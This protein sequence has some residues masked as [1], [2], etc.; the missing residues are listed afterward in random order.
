[1]AYVDSNLND[2][3][4]F[5]NTVIISKAPRFNNVFDYDNNLMLYAKNEIIK[6]IELGYG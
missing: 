6:S 2:P 3:S 1:M 5:F 4:L